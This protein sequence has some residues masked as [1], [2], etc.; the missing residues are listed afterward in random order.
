MTIGRMATTGLLSAAGKLRLLAEPLGD[1]PG[2]SESVAAFFERK[3]GREAYTNIVGPLFGGLYGSD[4]ADMS[5]ELTVGPLLRDLG[6]GRSLLLRLLARNAR[7]APSVSFT[8]GLEALPR[9]LSGALGS[10]LRL[11]CPVQSIRR[12]GSAWR[13]ATSED[14][15]EAQTV[16]LTSPADAT[17][18]MLAAT[19]PQ[20]AAVLSG[21]TYN[22]LAVVHLSAETDLD[23]TG[24]QVGLA[25]VSKRLRGVTFNHCLFRRSNLYTAFLGGS[26]HAGIAGM[27]EEQL[28]DEAVTGFRAYTGFEAEALSVTRTAMPAWDFGWR[29]LS[30][31][32]LPPGLHL[33]GNWWSRPGVAGRL[34]E[35]RAVASKLIAPA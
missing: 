31:L 32:R 13:V 7:T 5:A 8:E 21:L 27:P 33:A 22:P 16:V 30:A 15:L 25:E 11:S 9:A 23:A 35:G 20:I 12:V 3:L 29:A 10:R 34:T 26:E 19:E 14:E 24:F 17:R 28:I 1:G 18:R 2:R 4:P 6:V